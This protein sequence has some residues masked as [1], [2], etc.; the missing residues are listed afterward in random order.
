MRFS[1]RI[2]I[3]AALA[4]LLLGASLPVA[5][6][7]LPEVQRLIKAGQY[8]EALTQVDA[9]LAAHARDAQ[10]RFYK[11][12]ILTQLQRD[13]EAVAVF[14]RLTEEFPALPEPYNNLAVLYAR[15]QQYDRARAALEKAI[16]THPAYAVAYE[17]LGDIYARM[18][19]EAYGKALQLDAA[20]ANAQNKLALIGD[21]TGIP[22]QVQVTPP[23]P[24]TVT[25][26]KVA[27]LPTPA[28]PTTPAAQAP[29]PPPAPGKTG[30]G[31]TPPA[32]GKTPV[33]PPTLPGSAS[34]ALP[35]P[36]KL[37]PAPP[38]PANSAQELEKAVRNWAAAWSRQDIN[39]YLAA[40]APNFRTPRGI[41]RKQWEAERRDRISRPKWI[42]VELSDVQ[43]KAEGDMA[44][45]FF[46]QSYRASNFK[47]DSR[48]TLAFVRVDNRWLILDE[49]LR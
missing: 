37:P 22:G 21:L 47:G 34:T 29:S 40:Y 18:A 45:V 44:R 16:R 17:N 43:V 48:K 11:G 42:K 26:P 32:A 7:T 6:R 49:D 41:G 12:L 20:N 13:S 19:S 14:T 5:A 39:A 28:T 23:P 15:Q 46:R 24:V 9:Y 10:G 30:T 36:V 33:Q 38:P 31:T 3:F 2:R 25:P 8:A 1:V 35:A 27:P 4:G